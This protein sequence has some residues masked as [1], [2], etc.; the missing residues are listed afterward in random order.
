M[1]TKLENDI[2]ITVKDVF[3]ITLCTQFPFS[4]YISDAGNTQASFVLA[5]SKCSR[6]ILIIIADSACI[7]NIIVVFQ[8]G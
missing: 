1:S 6:F 7:W 2:H 8:E 4:I 5:F 3:V